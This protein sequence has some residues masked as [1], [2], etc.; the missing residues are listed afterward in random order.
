[1]SEGQLDAGGSGFRH[2]GF[3]LSLRLLQT[4]VIMK[5]DVTCGVLAVCCLDV[6]GL[7]CGSR[8]RLR[9]VVDVWN[10]LKIAGFIDQ[11]DQTDQ[12]SRKE[13]SRDC[14]RHGSDS[15]GKGVKTTS[16]YGKSRPS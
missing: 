11:A 10:S 13:I 5:K 12:I 7:D 3:L 4:E 16:S 1:M 8:S 6:A 9:P 15:D 2:A 14:G